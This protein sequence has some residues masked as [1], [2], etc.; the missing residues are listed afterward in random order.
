MACAELNIINGINLLRK[1][2]MKKLFFAESFNKDRT[3]NN[4]LLI[5]G[6]IFMLFAIVHFLHL[7]LKF[8]IVIAEYT[9]PNSVSIVGCVVGIVLSIWMFV[10]RSK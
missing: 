2:S 7:F 10:A 6:C 5:S 3:K 8:D 4:A 9:I 1:E